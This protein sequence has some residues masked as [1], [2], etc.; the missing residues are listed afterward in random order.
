MPTD[1]FYYIELEIEYLYNAPQWAY[2]INLRYLAHHR[3]KDCKFL[4]YFTKT[5][6][7]LKST[8][9]TL[10]HTNTSLTLTHTHTF[11]QNIY[12]CTANVRKRLYISP[13]M[14]PRCHFAMILLPINDHG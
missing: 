8:M 14:R 7:K 1:V 13:C 10:L 3:F 4:T 12:S 11:P 6:R 2:C 5:D 9:Y